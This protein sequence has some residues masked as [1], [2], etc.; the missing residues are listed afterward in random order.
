MKLMKRKI[1]KTE[2]LTMNNIKYLVENG[3]PISMFLNALIWA[4]REGDEKIVKLMIEAGA[5]FKTNDKSG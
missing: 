2:Q 5:K 1:I 4:I 3:A